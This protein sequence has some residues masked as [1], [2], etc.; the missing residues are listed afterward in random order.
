MCKLLCFSIMN[1]G[2]NT[3]KLKTL[4]EVKVRSQ[5]GNEKKERKKEKKFNIM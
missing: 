4:S 2:T 5:L 3:D 1:C